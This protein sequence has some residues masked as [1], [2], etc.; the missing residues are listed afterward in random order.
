MA[1]AETDPCNP[2]YVNSRAAMAALPPEYRAEPALA[3]AGADGMDLVRRILFRGSDCKQ[4]Q[5]IGVLVLESGAR[6]A[7]L[8][9]Q[10]RRPKGPAGPRLPTSAGDDSAADDAQRRWSNWPAPEFTQGCPRVLVLV[11][12]RCARGVTAGAGTSVT[13][14]TGRRSAWWAATAPVSPLFALAARQPA[15]E[16][17]RGC[18]CRRAG[19]SPAAWPSSAEC[20]DRRARPTSCSPA[21][22]HCG[23]R[24]SAWP[25]PRR[26]QSGVLRSPRRT[27]PSGCRRLRRTIAA[28]AMLMGLGFGSNEQL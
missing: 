1:R 16:R 25:P 17:R 27:R 14:A 26:R 18:R 4:T 23:S 5:R 21:T 9:G 3:L 19:S 7:P 20:R 15:A 10:W 13:P 12:S 11:T 22:R 2:P 24:R 6:R 28:Q 8:Q